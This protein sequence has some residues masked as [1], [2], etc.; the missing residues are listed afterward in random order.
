MQYAKLLVQ[1]LDRKGIEC[2]TGLHAQSGENWKMYMTKVEKA[3]IMIVIQTPDY[4][5]WVRDRYYTVLSTTTQ[6]RPHYSEVGPTNLPPRRPA[7][8]PI[9]R[10]ADPPTR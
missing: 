1:K 4:Y 3:E 6:E 10:P 9:R 2:F 8:P 7:D 5:R